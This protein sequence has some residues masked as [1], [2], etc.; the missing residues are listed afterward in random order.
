MRIFGG[1]GGDRV[2]EELEQKVMGRIPIQPDAS[3]EPGRSL[4]EESTDQARVFDEIAGNI[5]QTR[6][7]RR[8]KV[9]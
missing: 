6:V 4:F 9:L 8:L 3:G 1:D 5:A 7:R 2:A